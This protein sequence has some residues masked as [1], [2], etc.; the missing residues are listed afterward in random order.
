MPEEPRAIA[1]PIRGGRMEALRLPGGPGHPLLV[2][3]G[4]EAGLRPLAGTEQVLRRRWEGRTRARPVVVLG[5]PLPDDAADADRLMHPRLIADAAVAALARLATDGGPAPPFAVEAESGGGRIALW[6]TV[7]HPELV[8]GLVLAS[9]ASET[10]AGS[11]MAARMT[12]WIQMAEADDWGMF[13]SHMAVVM[14]ARSGP[15]AA[16]FEAAARLQPR[17]ATPARFIA[18][19]RATLDPTSFVTDRLGEIAVPALVLAGE[20][21]QVVPLAATRLVAERIP[22]ARLVTDPECGHT[23]RASLAGYDDVVE[24]FL[25]DTDA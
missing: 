14:K 25:A 1:L 19:L 8:S 4:V 6:L 22:G 15:E 20:K 3:G 9:V 16:S 10:P 18:E 2:L 21:D 23:V 11:P 7:D 12:R 13:F 24:A 17:P 5:R